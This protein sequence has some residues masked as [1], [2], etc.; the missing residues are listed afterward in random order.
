MGGADRDSGDRA[1]QTG[2]V[3]IGRGRQGQWGWGGGQTGTVGIG[4]GR[5]GQWG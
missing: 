1:G 3:G 5:Q 4:R 2:T